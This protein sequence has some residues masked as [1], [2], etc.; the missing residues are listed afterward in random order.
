MSHATLVK[1]RDKPEAA[2]ECLDIS[3]AEDLRQ[4]ARNLAVLRGR[5]AAAPEFHGS[6]FSL[7]AG[8]EDLGPDQSPQHHRPRRQVPRAACAKAS[9][10][11]KK[12][13]CA[14]ML[15]ISEVIYLGPVML[16]SILI[17]VGVVSVVVLILMLAPR[18]TDCREPNQR[19]LRQLQSLFICIPVTIKGER[20]GRTVC[21]GTRF[22]AY[23]KL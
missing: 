21:K 5:V 12:Q 1:I 10:P 17:Y 22:G 19:Q 20:S 14:R 15:A 9:P 3:G 2:E 13:T 18:W 4:C 11:H 16:S 23:K 6:V 7:K 8:F